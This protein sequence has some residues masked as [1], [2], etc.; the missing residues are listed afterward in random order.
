[1]RILIFLLAIILEIGCHYGRNEQELQKKIEQE[2]IELRNREIRRENRVI[3]EF[4]HESMLA[5]TSGLDHEKASVV[6]ISFLLNDHPAVL[7]DLR[8]IRSGNYRYEESDVPES[9]PENKTEAEIIEEFLQKFIRKVAADDRSLILR[10]IVRPF[11][12]DSYSETER[13]LH[14]V[15]NDRRTANRR[16]TPANEAKQTAEEGQVR[17]QNN[18]YATAIGS[19]MVGRRLNEHRSIGSPEEKKREDQ[20]EAREDVPGGANENDHRG[21]NDA[22]EDTSNVEASA[23]G[24][25]V[26][27]HDDVRAPT[28]GRKRQPNDLFFSVE[29]NFYGT[30]CQYVAES[31]APNTP[32]MKKVPDTYPTN[33][34]KKCPFPDPGTGRFDH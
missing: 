5:I 31:K 12:L 24:H 7:S 14:K 10:T 3:A 15:E 32:L 17:E 29:N 22:S 18:G 25:I 33:K 13:F 11:F 27:V 2:T 30:V 26:G 8:T 28:D 20:V 4:F 9:F 6:I 23:E 21:H 16:D 19:G 34:L 1:V